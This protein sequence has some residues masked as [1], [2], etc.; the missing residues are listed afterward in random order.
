MS[1]ISARVQIYSLPNQ[2]LTLS[3]IKA[4]G[5]ASLGEYVRELESEIP[6]DLRPKYANL[7]L[8]SFSSFDP[9]TGEKEV[10]AVFD[11]YS[12][13]PSDPSDIGDADSKTIVATPV[14]ARVVSMENAQ[15]SAQSGDGDIP[16]AYINS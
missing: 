8:V 16:G 11:D 5:Y 2:P 10:L 6:K 14:S 9:K 15:L 7:P 13:L 3:D 1:E 12:D 4:S